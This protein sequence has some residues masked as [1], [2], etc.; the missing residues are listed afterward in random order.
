[1]RALSS[2]P[3]LA[4]R[5]NAGQVRENADVCTIDVTAAYRHRP[6]QVACNDT[7]VTMGSGRSATVVSMSGMSDALRA[8]RQ[9]A[10]GL[11]ID[12]ELLRRELVVALE[13]TRAANAGTSAREARL[14]TCG[15]QN[16][17]L[18]ADGRCYDR[19]ELG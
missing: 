18:G 3:K 10:A 8:R 13:D 15:D 4:L 5:C 2:A 16:K 7:V 11:A 19:S 14:R 6:S 1:M 12:A 17:M 9:A